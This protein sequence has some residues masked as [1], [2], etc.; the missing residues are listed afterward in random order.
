MPIYNQSSGYVTVPPYSTGGEALVFRSDPGGPDGRLLLF[1]RSGRDPVR[2]GDPGSYT[3]PAYSP[4][5]KTLAYARTEPGTRQRDIW[6]FDLVRS[7]PSRFTFSPAE[8]MNPTWSPDGRRIAY[9]SDRKG[10]RD[11]YLKDSGGSGPEE[12]LIES[13]IEKSVEDWSPDGKFILYNQVAPSHQREL[14]AVPVEGVREPFPVIAGPTASHRGVFSPNGR[15]LAYVS[16]ESG[17]DEVYV[18]TFP[19]S[20]GKWQISTSGGTDPK[21]SHNGK[22]LFYARGDSFVA[23]KVDSISPHFTFGPP[24]ELFSFPP[25]GTGRNRC[26]VSPDDQHFICVA[27]G[28]RV[29][30]SSLT[31]VLNWT[32]TLPR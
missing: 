23:L 14:W 28:E 7:L 24:R 10:V 9:I 15:Y 2:L 6:L 19:P 4:D 8:E 13:S 3:N 31:V 17:P 16:S 1:D 27:R 25:V 21:W 11:I 29:N 18:Q 20:G 30:G 12:V 22:E 26:T 32:A 5:G